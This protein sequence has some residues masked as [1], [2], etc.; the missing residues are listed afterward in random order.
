MKKLSLNICLAIMLFGIS[1]TAFA[2]AIYV[3]AAPNVYGSS[4]YPAWEINAFAAAAN[5]T[6]INMANSINP[7]NIGTTN[8]EIQDEVV[9]SFG[10]LG[11]RLTW[12]Y[13]LPGETLEGLK[14]NFSIALFNIWDGVLLDFYQDYYGSTWLEPTKWK[15]FDSDGDGNNDGVIGAA[16]MAWWGAYQVN[17]QEA[18]DADIAQWSYASES[19][20][21]KT[22]LR[23]EVT[24]LRVDR[25]AVPE[26]S[27]LF[28]LGA[29]LIGAV[30]IGKK[31]L[32]K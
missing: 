24:E 12:I 13:W 9:Y 14:G 15:E 4:A 7:A 10:D 22:N 8:F 28:L 25:E 11:K 3:D 16:G 32:F 1:G 2:T 17:T 29:G 5:G 27:T 6:F 20:I 23:G 18:L 30:T 21:F 26:P 31:K 19:W